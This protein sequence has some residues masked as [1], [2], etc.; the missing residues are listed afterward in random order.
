MFLWNVDKCLKIFDDVYVSS[1]SDEILD[2]AKICGAIPIKRP[3]RL[4][5][6]TPNIPVYRH[7]QKTIGADVIVAVQANSPTIDTLIIRKIF[8]IMSTGSVR[9]LMTVH[10]NHKIYG[11]VWA[12]RKDKLEAYKDFHHPKPEMSL[13]DPSIDIHTLKDFKEAEEQ[14]Q[15]IQVL[16]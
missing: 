14:W 2:L 16:S 8:N 6:D 1:D 7:A 5:G 4:C 11:S 13:I 15:S 10:E 3:K 9:E 12:I